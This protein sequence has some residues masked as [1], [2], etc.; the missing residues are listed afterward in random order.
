MP[1]IQTN[2]LT[3]TF[4]ESVV[5]V[6]SLDLTIE[7]GEIFGFLGP[8]GAGKSTTINMLL[9]F[10]RPTAGSAEVFG[11]DAQSECAAIRERIGVLP[12]GYGFDDYLTGREYMEWAVETKGADD[13]PEHLLDLVGI[14]EDAGRVASGYSK[15]MQQRLAF[16]MAL[17]DDPDLLI[18]DEPSTGL[19]PNGI[20]HMRSVIRDRASEGTTVF[21]SSHI[22]SEVEAVCDRVGVMNEGELVAIDSIE[23][24]RESATGQA[25]IELECASVPPSEDV[26]YIDGVSAVDVADTTLT[27]QCSDPSAKVEVVKRVDEQVDVVDILADNT[28]LEEL[29]NQFTGGGRDGDGT[30]GE[31]I[32]L[33]ESQEASA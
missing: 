32:D 13:D 18:L 8:N 25:T 19:D 2:G 24:L 20:Q 7:E 4:G 22:L 17:A 26:A 3:K 33:E 27:A 9:D 15:G 10:I 31:G 5:A 28:S 16:G 29:F 30:V 14:R 21:F 6:D 23:G 12:E 1:S 11:M